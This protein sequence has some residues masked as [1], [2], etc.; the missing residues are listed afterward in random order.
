M[1]SV[2]IFQDHTL[3]SMLTKT[4]LPLLGLNSSALCPRG[5]RAACLCEPPI[6]RLSSAA[7]SS[8]QHRKPTMSTVV[9]YNIG[10]ELVAVSRCGVC[11][12]RPLLAG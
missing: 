1:I 4:M 2:V 3:S 7:A 9:I 6:G 10:T 11:G 12:A 5:Q 8:R